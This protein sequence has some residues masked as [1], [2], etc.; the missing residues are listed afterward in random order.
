MKNILLVFIFTS[1]VFSS[2]IKE[3]WTIA[4]NASKTIE[5]T[6]E[7]IKKNVDNQQKNI[8]ITKSKSYYITTYGSFKTYKEAND[9]FKTLPKKL[10]VDKP[11]ILKSKNNLK[12]PKK[13]KNLVKVIEPEKM[14]KP[15]KVSKKET[16]IQTV[17]VVKKEIQTI[18]KKEK[19]TKPTT[20]KED[21]EKAKLAFKEKKYQIAYD[22]F[23]K[24][25]FNDLE[26]IEIN[27]FLGRSAFEL[28]QYDDALIAYE[29]VIIQKPEMTRVQ[30]EIARTYF[31]QK[32]YHQSKQ[33]FNI[34]K[35]GKHPKTVIDNVNRYLAIID[36][37]VSKHTLNGIFIAGAVY[38]S[39]LNN[40]ASSDNFYVPA[41]QNINNGVSTNTTKDVSAFAHQEILILNHNYR[42]NRNINLKNDIMF[43]NKNVIDHSEK[44][45]LLFSYSPSLE[46]TY[47]DKLTLTYGLFA[48]RLYFGSPL[49]M[50]TYGL[51]PKFNYKLS[52]D[53][54]ISGSYKYQLKRNK[55][56]ANK[57][58]DSTYQQLNL[59]IN[60]ILTP[61]WSSSNSVIIEK[62]RKDEGTVTSVDFD[63]YT[64]SLGL[65]Y[66]YS[67]KLSFTPKITYKEKTN[68]DMDTLYLLK[69]KN[70]EYNY[71]LTGTYILPKGW[72]GQCIFNYSDIKSNVVSAE[73][74]KHTLGVNFI[75]PF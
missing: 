1:L 41:L 3:N 64:L 53:L 8:F 44:N 5:L 70:K 31:M 23:Y 6:E 30:L 15:K 34:I 17:A 57:S 58:K 39:N 45:V 40:R 18:K 14:Q 49:L 71:N 25:F 68:K 36:K 16:L 20:N 59:T 2:Q 9:F 60:K 38:D 26:N 51:L 43:F 19:T 21:L 24:L 67:K 4:L 48:D 72:I 27:Y 55:Q 50:D 29:R 12:Y 65:S 35:K 73:Y 54:S 74:K 46:H 33:L 28:K 22:L 66:K 75:K 42:Y 62:D 63:A 61:T 11:Y 69:Q 13:I 52:K 7:F 37:K 56:T 47:S 10:M 32:D